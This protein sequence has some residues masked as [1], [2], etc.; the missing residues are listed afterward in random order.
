MVVGLPAGN[1]FDSNNISYVAD[2]S[3]TGK[4]ASREHTDENRANS[5]KKKKKK[6]H[7]KSTRVRNVSC[8]LLL[9]FF[10]K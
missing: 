10:S 7:K 8:R 1:D 2:V 6:K 9:Y 3:D 4:P 5:A